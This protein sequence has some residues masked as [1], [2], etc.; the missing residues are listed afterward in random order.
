VAF[1]RIVIRPQIVGDL[2]W[3]RGSYDSIRGTIAVDWRLDNNRLTLK[4]TVPGNTSATVYVPASDPGKVLESGKAAA[5]APGV[6]PAGTEHGTAVY[7]VESGQYVF[8][9]PRE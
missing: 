3:A 5:E 4:V 6:A 8:T 7:H 9:A 2:R 1:K